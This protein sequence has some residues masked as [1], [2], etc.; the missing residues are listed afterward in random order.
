VPVGRG[1]DLGTAAMTNIF[2]NQNQFLRTTKKKL[3]HN[4]GDM[5]EVLDIELNENA[6]TPHEYRTLRNIL[7][8]F[9]VK[10]N[11]VIFMVKKQTWLARTASYIMK[12]RRDT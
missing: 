7:R 6:D 1:A 9:R 11:Q 12:T 3:V 2:H 5:D 10:D 4:L 8:I